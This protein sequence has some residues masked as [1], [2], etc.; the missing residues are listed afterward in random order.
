[1]NEQPLVSAIVST[2]NSELFIK[3]KIEDLLEQTIA[4]KLEIII[5]NSGSKQDE[6]SIVKQFLNKHENINYIKTDNRETIYK[7]WNRGIKVAKGKYITNANTDDRLKKDAYEKLSSFLESKIEIGLVFANQYISHIS[8]EKY[9]E[10]KYFKKWDIPEFD[11]LVQLDRCVVLSQPMWR[12]SIHHQFNIWFNEQLEICG[13]HE[14]DLKILEHYKIKY[15]PEALGLF[16]VAPDKSNKSLQDQTFLEKERTDMTEKYII[17]YVNKLTDEQLHG[18]K[19]SFKKLVGLPIP[20]LR[21]RNIIRKYVFPSQHPFTH[22]FVHFVYALI[23]EKLGKRKE[24]VYYCKK[25]LKW[26]NSERVKKL[27][28]RLEAKN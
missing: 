1:V 28:Y 23:Q 3:G 2:Y 7:A 26:K 27:L 4:D 10:I 20:V 13:D 18:L 6:D 8:N 25:L 9:K 12:S 11:Y 14:F 15:L 5:I 16:Y 22:E 21:G 17:D 19:K 24:A